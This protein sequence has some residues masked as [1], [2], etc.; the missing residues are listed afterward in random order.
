MDAEWVRM[1]CGYGCGVDYFG[2]RIR[3]GLGS[4]T[5]KKLSDVKFV[6]SPYN[7]RAP[8]QLAIIRW[9]NNI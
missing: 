3:C 7:K 8:I 2:R 1:M 4:E 5:N 9:Q 6:F